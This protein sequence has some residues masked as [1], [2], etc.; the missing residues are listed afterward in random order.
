MRS[1]AWASTSRPFSKAMPRGGKREGSGPKKKTP[2]PKIRKGVAFEVL[3]ELG[4]GV[5]KLNPSGKGEVVRWI[6]FLDSKNEDTALR[7]L[8]RLTDSVDGT[9]K[10]KVEIDPISFDPNEPLK[11]IIEHIGTGA[12]ASHVCIAAKTKQSS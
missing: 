3:E 10:Q 5:T 9:A 8:S 1:P 7:A 6:E 4:K 2:L 12:S 11:V